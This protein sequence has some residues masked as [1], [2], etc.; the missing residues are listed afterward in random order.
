MA[1]DD[2]L[3]LNRECCQRHDCRCGW[4]YDM[5]MAVSWRAREMEWHDI[6]CLMRRQGRWPSW[7]YSWSSLNTL[8][9]LVWELATMTQFKLPGGRVTRWTRRLRLPRNAEFSGS[10]SDL[11]ISFCSH[12]SA[13]IRKFERRSF[14]LIGQLRVELLPRDNVF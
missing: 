4:S 11:H 10:L 3:H 13:H 12:F 9:E 14:D 8:C 2:N 7:G 5:W 6:C 1:G